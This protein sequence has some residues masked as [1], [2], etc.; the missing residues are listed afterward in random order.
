MEGD[1]KLPRKESLISEIREWKQIEENVEKDNRIKDP[2]DDV[3][4]M[5]MRLREYDR[6]YYKYR[7][8]GPFTKDE[9]AYFI[10]LQF[11]R[12]KIRKFLYP[13]Q[14]T[15]MFQSAKVAFQAAFSQYQAARAEKKQTLRDYATG[16]LELPPAIV[17]DNKEPEANDLNIPTNTTARYGQDLGRK[18]PPAPEQHKGHSL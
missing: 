18:Q 11:Q 16:K 15:R 14:L 2:L 12:K 7:D 9:Q 1:K 13:R 6:I 3:D 4:Y 5:K 17:S 10:V 8:G